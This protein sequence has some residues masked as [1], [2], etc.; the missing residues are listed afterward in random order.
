M[1]YS[2]LITNTE[3]ND[4][5]I[6]FNPEG[7]DGI[8]FYSGDHSSS[9]DFLSIS[10]LECYVYLQFDLGSG[11]ADLMSAEPVA[12]GEWHTVYASRNGKSALLRV[13]DQPVINMMSPGIFQEL[14]TVG[15][16]SLGGI[17]EYSLVSPLTGMETGFI[18][19]IL[20]MQV[21]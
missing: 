10:L 4:I 15:D 12:L 19:C 20:S 11:L 17:Q 5:K 14:N 13:N 1:E 9:R 21:N 18:G 8:L 16:V 2:E 3:N 6:V 7:P